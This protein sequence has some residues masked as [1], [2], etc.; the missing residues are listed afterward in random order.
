MAI[1]GWCMALVALCL[2]ETGYG[3]EETGGPPP[4]PGFL[5]QRETLLSRDY[6]GFN[7][8]I[9]LALESDANGFF[10]RQVVEATNT[11][12]RYVYKT[13]S[14]FSAT[15]V[16]DGNQ[17][18]WECA[19][20]H[21]GQVTID[22]FGGYSLMQLQVDLG[23]N[24]LEFVYYEKRS[25]LWAQIDRRM[26]I[27]EMFTRQVQD[28]IDLRPSAIKLLG[29]FKVRSI[30]N[31]VT[32]IGAQ[33][34][35]MFGH[36]IKTIKFGRR[37]LWEYSP[38]V[39][40]VC[41]RVD[42]VG[43][44]GVTLLILHLIEINE[45]YRVAYMYGKGNR[46]M[47]KQ[48]YLELYKILSIIR[49]VHVP[50]VRLQFDV[51]IKPDE[52]AKQVKSSDSSTDDDE[53]EDS[54]SSQMKAPLIKIIEDGDVENALSQ[55]QS[56]LNTWT[57]EQLEADN[58]IVLEHAGGTV[59][60]NMGIP[61]EQAGISISTIQQDNGDVKRN[62]I[63]PRRGAFVTCLD[64][65]ERR[66]YTA[67]DEYP[68]KVVKE[69]VANVLVVAIFATR[70]DG[71]AKRRYFLRRKREWS[72]TSKVGYFNTRKP[73][74]LGRDVDIDEM[75]TSNRIF[76][77]NKYEGK[78]LA[79]YLNF[80]KHDSNVDVSP[81]FTYSVSRVTYK[82]QDLWV[83]NKAAF[84]MV[85]DIKIWQHEEE[86]VL[87]ITTVNGRD[88]RHERMFLMTNDKWDLVEEGAFVTAY[89]TPLFIDAAKSKHDGLNTITTWPLLPNQDNTMKPLL[90]NYI[91]TVTYGDQM[92]W[93]QEGKD[94]MCDSVYN[95]E[96]RGVVI[97]TLK[98]YDRY[99]DTYYVYYL[100]D[101]T[102]DKWVEIDVVMLTFLVR[103]LQASRDFADILKKYEFTA[104]KFKDIIVKDAKSP[105]VESEL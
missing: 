24:P 87:T 19:Y 80:G 18:L 75:E 90:G 83:F 59:S 35:P 78:W 15:R 81:K 49:P 6:T 89:K 40:T 29:G 70:L 55:E 22:D 103:N 62:V 32:P 14:S 52:N 95:I 10:T 16:I 42:K 3:Q 104:G 102:N 7:I 79:P 17:T 94:Y 60:W 27:K 57:C 20:K 26:Y 2:L 73:V 25:A 54:D 38:E 48:K 8:L 97:V 44:S 63:T 96:I 71:M 43:A 69:F 91:H 100:N 68:H 30:K 5:V 77:N 47:K 33:V 34:A 45:R 1:S 105:T 82:K 37:T 4:N 9:D 101:G 39:Q 65:G 23:E 85:T 99:G 98:V 64:D 58:S 36:V 66:V 74:V 50:N 88:K 72:E 56:K 51:T 86:R 11:H 67:K 53:D 61:Q 28:E 92:L 21:A 13:R 12:T 76:Y 31:P 84:E 93:K 46:T 41:I